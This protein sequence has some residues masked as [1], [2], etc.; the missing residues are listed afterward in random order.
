[1]EKR[2]L[3][4]EDETSLQN[5]YLRLFGSFATVSVAANG[6]EGLEFLQQ[7]DGQGTRYDLIITDANMPVMDGF[8]FLRSI[9]EREHLPP[10]VMYSSP[11][12]STEKEA[13]QQVLALGGLGLI[14][15]P[16]GIDFLE[17]VVQELLV[18]NMSPTLERYGV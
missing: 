13:H 8:E 15:K 4:L 2:L 5:M 18:G 11:I 9:Q 12:H 3:C 14:V 6:Q 10:R 1:M 17:A 16:M 7:A